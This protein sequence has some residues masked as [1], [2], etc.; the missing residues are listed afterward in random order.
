MPN[1]KGTRIEKGVFI[2]GNGR[3]R[4]VKRTKSFN[5]HGEKVYG[6]KEQ[7]FNTIEECRDWRTQVQTK[8]K[9]ETFTLGD[10]IA[11]ETLERKKST[12]WCLYAQFHERMLSF[13]GKQKPVEDISPVEI[14]HWRS[15]LKNQPLKRGV[16]KLSDSYVRNH[17][18]CLR[19]Y[20]N[21]VEFNQLIIGYR[22]PKFK[23][24]KPNSKRTLKIYLTEFLKICEHLPLPYKAL[25]WLALNTG[26][27]KWDLFRM[28]KSQIEVVE[29]M[30]NGELVTQ[31]YILADSTK[32]KKTNIRIPMLKETESVLQE[33]QESTHNPTE[34]LLLNPLGRPIRD[35][36]NSIDNACKAAGVPRITLHI[37]RHLAITTLMDIT[38]S[39]V[40]LV[41]EITGASMEVIKKHYDHHGFGERYQTTFKGFDNLITVHQSKVPKNEGDSG[42]L[43]P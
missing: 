6:K 8:Q 7:T 30:V 1:Q 41:S 5:A 13:W 3:Y 37:L 11:V 33:Y 20:L 15:Y 25:F 2:L 36:Q 34:F 17:L 32:T 27:R 12:T 43:A 21:A 42:A 40:N 29:E 39:N 4:A 19:A 18:A 14:I 26:S 28:K 10:L 16:G 23:L 38:E 35:M 22:A 24:E 9:Q 31:K